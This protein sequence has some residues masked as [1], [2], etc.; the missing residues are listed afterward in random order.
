M[1]YP[2]EYNASKNKISKRKLCMEGR[3]STGDQG[4]GVG[5]GGVFFSGCLGLMYV[6]FPY[7]S[8]RVLSPHRKM[9]QGGTG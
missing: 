1:K 5:E 2:G 9:S 8:K 7:L 6:P 3:K 4:T